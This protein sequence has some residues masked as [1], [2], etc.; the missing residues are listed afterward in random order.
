MQ[1]AHQSIVEK[2]NLAL[3]NEVMACVGFWAATRRKQERKRYER[4]AV[5]ALCRC[6]M[7]D[8][9][10]QYIAPCTATGH[11][12]LDSELDVNKHFRL[13]SIHSSPLHQSVSVSTGKTIHP[14]AT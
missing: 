11:H 9:G 8:E 3:G 4:T 13:Y 5:A 10:T 7:V 2:N 1:I 6:I 12:K 14:A